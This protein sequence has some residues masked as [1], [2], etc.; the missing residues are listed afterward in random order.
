MDDHDGIIDDFAGLFQ[1]TPN[2]TC[3]CCQGTEWAPVPA[4]TAMLAP[5]EPTLSAMT[6]IDVLTVEP[7]DDIAVDAVEG[8]MSVRGIACQT[9]GF[10]RIHVPLGGL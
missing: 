3:P 8:F 6:G 1:V 9:C 2:A 4:L 7:T 10:L 5:G